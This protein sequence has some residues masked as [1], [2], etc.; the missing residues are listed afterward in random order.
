MC[1]VVSRRCIPEQS[2]SPSG[3]FAA[4]FQPCGEISMNMHA[5]Y[6]TDD[7]RFH[8]GEFLCGT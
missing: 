2:L 6:V 8:V 1:S 3:Q 4:L 7:K 5:V